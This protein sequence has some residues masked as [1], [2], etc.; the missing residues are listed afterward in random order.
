MKTSSSGHHTNAGTL[1]KETT[2][3]DTSTDRG[4]DENERLAHGNR[5]LRLAKA[6]LKQDR[7]IAREIKRESRI[8]EAKALQ[9]SQAARERKRLHSLHM[10]TDAAVTLQCL[11]MVQPLSR[12]AKQQQMQAI[13]RAKE[14][15][16]AQIQ[17][18][19]TDASQRRRRI[20]SF[21]SKMRQSVRQPSPA[22]DTPAPIPRERTQGSPLFYLYPWHDMGRYSKAQLEHM[23]LHPADIELLNKVATECLVAILEHGRHPLHLPRAAPFLHEMAFAAHVVGAHA[24]A[25][26]ELKQPSLL[27]PL[28]I[29][30]K[31]RV[32][33]TVRA[34]RTRIV[35]IPGHFQDDRFPGQAAL[36]DATIHAS[37]EVL[38]HVARWTTAPPPATTAAQLQSDFCE[39]SAWLQRL[40][41]ETASG[42]G[43]AFVSNAVKA[44]CV[45]LLALVQASLLQQWA[46]WAADEPEWFALNR[47]HL[48]GLVPV[49]AHLDAAVAAVVKPAGRATLAAR[50]PKWLQAHVEH[51]TIADARGCLLSEEV[52]AAYRDEMS[53]HAETL[54][55]IE[56]VRMDH[57]VNKAW[58]PTVRLNVLLNEAAQRLDALT[59]EL[60]LHEW[61]VSFIQNKIRNRHR[62]ASPMRR[63]IKD[64]AIDHEAK[65]GD[66]SLEDQPSAPAIAQQAP[67]DE[68]DPANEHDPADDAA[69]VD[70]DASDDGEACSPTATGKLKDTDKSWVDGPQATE[71]D[72]DEAPRRRCTIDLTNDEDAVEFHYEDV[73]MSEE[74]EPAPAAPPEPPRASVIDISD[75][76]ESEDTPG[77][78]GR[79]VLVPNTDEPKPARRTDSD[80]DKA[81]TDTDEERP[82][83]PPRRK[84]SVGAVPLPSNKRPCDARTR[85]RPKPNAAIDLL[86]QQAMA[87]MLHA[88]ETDLGCATGCGHNSSCPRCKRCERHCPCRPARAPTP[89]RRPMPPPRPAS[90]SFMPTDRLRTE[91]EYVFKAAADRVRRRLRVMDPT[92][93]AMRNYVRCLEG[94]TLWSAQRIVGLWSGSKD[95]YGVLGVPRHATWSTVKNQY[96]TLVLKLHPDKSANTPENVSAFMAVNAAYK[97][98]RATFQPSAT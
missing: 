43:L 97:R 87:R 52:L 88:I 63:P 79:F 26:A 65:Q 41:V 7:Y 9:W 24:Y 46:S 1:R 85:F 29:F 51:F 54:R 36:V 55:Y 84:R 72:L 98:L 12:S 50:D 60:L 71:S 82:G 30:E 58:D 34:L 94:P 35:S 28:P 48:E 44:M 49:S 31:A 11:A 66:K 53:T 91:Q 42:T 3:L 45:R 74:E 8:L 56:Y 75:A 25:Q 96:R 2:A 80:G 47:K 22:L 32:T 61:C 13:E 62:I 90:P 19:P 57:A 59:K 6:H 38:H 92:A 33:T 10:V 4:A 20:R 16:V 86:C 17:Q 89:V 37:P 76:S 73:S 23:L 77:P 15:A 83:S 95:A 27:F 40:L 39:V 70:P 64:E 81:P 18:I 21:E 67:V 14:I 93:P 69:E 78:A 68:H 5:A